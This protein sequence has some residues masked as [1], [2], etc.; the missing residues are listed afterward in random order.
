M[1]PIHDIEIHYR[2]PLRYGEAGVVRT[3]IAQNLPHAHGL[4]P[5][6]LPCGGCS[7]ANTADGIAGDPNAEG[8][9]ALGRR[10]PQLREGATPVVD[11]LVTVCVVERDTFKPVS[12]RRTFP[13]LTPSTRTSWKRLDRAPPLGRSPQ[14]R[15]SL[16]IDILNCCILL[17]MGFVKCRILQ[18][19]LNKLGAQECATR[20]APRKAL[21]HRVRPNRL[22][23]P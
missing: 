4:P 10:E 14:L 6:G 17:K 23:E 19:E 15:V 13:D 9:A 3:S 18:F 16:I 1:S 21:P 11:A 5:A 20:P 22:S 8:A 2:S 7:E 12:L